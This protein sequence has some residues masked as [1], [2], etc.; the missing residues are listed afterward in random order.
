MMSYASLKFISLQLHSAQDWIINRC[1]E[2]VGIL[3]DNDTHTKT[4]RTPAVPD[5]ILQKDTDGEPCE[6]KWEYQATIRAL[7]YL[8][9]MT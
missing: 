3:L 4:H 7:N 6:Q 5:I 1:L 2:I 8:H 9:A